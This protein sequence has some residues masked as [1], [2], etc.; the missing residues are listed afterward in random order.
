MD[1][2]ATA[3]YA[4]FNEFGTR[5]MAAQPFIRPALDANQQRLLDAMLLGVMNSFR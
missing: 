1:F 2:G 3:D 5:R 4:S